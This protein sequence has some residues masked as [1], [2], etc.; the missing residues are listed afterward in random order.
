M[1]YLT[2]G[3]QIE[4]TGHSSGDAG[5]H[6]LGVQQL[7]DAS[8]VSGDNEYAPLQLNSVGAL[9][10]QPSNPPMSA[11]NQS[12]A[13]V[14]GIDALGAD[15]TTVDGVT[16]TLASTAEFTAGQT[17]RINSE[18]MTI[19]SVDD[20][21]TLTVTRG[22]F[23]STAVDTHTS[24]DA[25]TGA[26]VGVGE[27][28]HTSDVMVSLTADVAG[29]EY[30]E[31]SNDDAVWSRF[32]VAGFAVTANIHEFHTAVKGGRYFR[33]VFVTSSATEST[34]FNLYTYYGQ[35]RLGSA[36]L[37]QGIGDDSDAIVVR[38][39]AVAADPNGDYINKTGSGVFNA[40]SSTAAL[41]AST[42]LDG[43]IVDADA[44]TITVNSVTGLSAG[45]T[46]KINDEYV[47]I[48]A[49]SDPDLT[50]CTRGAF[51]TTNTTHADTDT[52]TAAFVGVWAD[53]KNYGGVSVSVDGTA[54]AAAP[55]TL[56][57]QFSHDGTT[58]HRSIVISIADIA[59]AAP[60]TLGVITQYFRVVYENGSVAQTT[61]TVQAMFHEQQVGL[62]S[63]LNQN[64][65]DDSDVTNVRAIVA[66][67]KPDDTFGNTRQ[68]G[69]V[70][71]VGTAATSLTLASSTLDGAILAGDTGNIALATGEAANFL[72]SGGRAWIGT[73]AAGEEITFTGYSG[74]NLTGVARG[75]GGTTAVDHDSGA[76]VSEMYVSTILDIEAYAQIQAEIYSDVTGVFL[77]S[78]YEDDTDQDTSTVIRRFTIEY[79]SLELE[80]FSTVRLTRYNR[81]AFYP[82]ASAQT[83][84]MLRYNLATSAISGQT[85][86]VDAFVAGSMVANL[87]RAVIM[88]KQPDGDFVNTPA[89]GTAFATTAVLAADAAYVSDWTDSDGWNVITV[90]VAASHAS[91][92]G[93]IEVQYT[94]DV[95]GDPAV[96]RASRFFTFNAGD[97]D[98]GFLTLTLPVMLDGFRVVYTNGATLQTSFLLQADLRTTA[99]SLSFNK[100]RALNVTDF[101]AEVALGE[102]PNY[103]RM[104]K[105]GRHDGVAL[106][107]DDITTAGGVYEGHSNSTAV[108]M[109]VV[110]TS[111]NDGAGDASGAL[112]VEV[113]GLLTP[114]S[115]EYTSEI[116]TL[117]GAT[118]VDL[119][120]SWYRINRA[121]VLTAGSTGSNVGTITIQGDG[122]G[123]IFCQITPA[124]NQSSDA[125]YT[126]PANQ[127][128]L[129]KTIRVQITDDGRDVENALV[130]LRYKD[131]GMDIYRAV[132]QY[133]V[134]TNMSV[135][136][137]PLTGLVF[138]GGV[139]LKFRCE[140]SSKATLV[141]NAQI[142][143]LLIRDNGT[144]YADP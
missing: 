76:M 3:V 85:V 105:F 143:G 32:P 121:Y 41:A 125:V 33:V 12:T 67:Q 19:D 66:G 47:T 52:V 62:V 115:E 34:D 28:V 80:N 23:A 57:M 111:P 110:S 99:S 71:D 11:I 13:N 112:T 119:A 109:E 135:I 100:A 69:N 139:D 10:T 77:G 74:D 87:S 72:A 75:K 18:Y 126:V 61:F 79:S 14:G 48:G 122:G 39:V 131:S 123:D 4:D 45:Q 128:L 51:G 144:P 63:R 124:L 114:T 133:D 9:K 64:I 98:R 127:R 120:S 93:G 43:A 117:N 2:G 54:G 81:V 113:Y 55:G 37:N 116:V 8:M 130:T 82:T 65:S 50:G 58:V 59:S 78:W 90:F 97:V 132:R 118:A 27:L 68:S 38:A 102:V 6:V 53:V 56:R 31:F 142:E 46:I 136:D 16:L 42:T 1:V 103:G 95:Q 22:Q 25:V 7:V 30:F 88:G 21:T 49:V 94:D 137:V 40:N 91:A 5:T 26:Y 29:T 101:N 140:T 70:I 17:I 36:P 92:V 35:F 20:G 141:A 107:G 60:R 96:T 86:G 106:A 24:G 134:T 138:E 15:V 83:A 104:D 84:M 108:A 89:D 129:L 44:T 73:I